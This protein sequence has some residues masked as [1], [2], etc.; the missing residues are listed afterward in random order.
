MKK[1][2]TTFM[3]MTALCVGY[4]MAEDIADVTPENFVDSWNN[5]ADGDVLLLESGTYSSDY[6][7]QAD[8]TITIKAA[9]GAVVLF[10]KGPGFTVDGG[11]SGIIMDGVTIEF[12]GLFI[13]LQAENIIINCIQFI[14]CTIQNSGNNAVAA[15]LANLGNGTIKN[16]TIDK[17][18]FKD[19]NDSSGSAAGKNFLF[20]IKGS[21][22]DNFV[23]RNSTFY[24]LDFRGFYTQ[25]SD[26]SAPISVLVENNTICNWTNLN[27]FLINFYRGTGSAVFTVKNNIFFTTPTVSQSIFR[28]RAGALTYGNNLTI[29]YAKAY[30]IS[31]STASSADIDASAFI[32]IADIFTDAANGDFTLVSETLIDAGIG[33]PRWIDEDPGGPT[34]IELVQVEDAPLHVNV[35]TIDGRIIR[36]NVEKTKALENLDRGIYIV[37]GKKVF[38]TK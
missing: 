5:A 18:I 20:Y 9:E 22:V 30:E 36:N 38:V 11:N 7:L 34:G 13:N 32:N 4:V 6:K 19:S 31:N 37:N 27:D 23:V 28:A 16:I 15:N 35:Y 8:K 12:T 25:E 24:N 21:Q 17:C 2:I 26:L 10:T 29:G 14:N 1:L 3:L 33:D